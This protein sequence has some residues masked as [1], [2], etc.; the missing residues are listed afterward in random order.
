MLDRFFRDLR[1]EPDLA[2]NIVHWHREPARNAVLSEFPDWTP[3]AVREAFARTGVEQLWSHQRAAA[4]LAHAGKHVAVVTPTASGKTLCYN[5]PVLT[6]LMGDEPTAATVASGIRKPEAGPSEMGPP[7]DGARA[8]YLFPTKAL[9]RDQ[10]ASF[11]ELTK[12]LPKRIRAGVYDGDTPPAT[13][14]TLRAAADVVVTNPYMLHAGILPHHLRWAS[15]FRDLR[16]VV[17]DEMHTLTGVLGS[18]VANVLRRL[19]R[20]CRHHGS[21]PTFLF[22]SATLANPGELA[23]NLIGDARAGNARTETDHTENNRTEE[24]QSGRERV[25]VLSRCGA[26]SPERHLLL[27]NPPIVDEASGARFSALEEARRI[28]SYALRA[29]LQTLVFARS[30]NSVE[31]LTK[32]L[33]DTAHEL[34]LDPAIV[35]GYRGGYLPNLRREVECGLR[36]GSVRV[37]VATNALELGIDVGGLDVVILTGY[38][39]RVASARQQA[40]RSGRRGQPGTAV[41]VARSDPLD[42]YVIQHPE[43]LLEGHAERAAIDPLNKLI[44]ANHVRCAAFE[45]PFREGELLWG[46]TQTTGVLEGLAAPGGPLHRSGGRYHWCD[47]SFPADTVSLNGFDID[48]VAIYDLEA[49]VVLAEVDRASAPFF[50]HEGAI[51]GHQG[52]TYYVERFD[53]DGRRAYVRKVDCDYY[54]DAEAEVEVRTTAQDDVEQFAV[55]SGAVTSVAGTSGAGTSGAG[56]SGA[57][58][59]N[60]VF[61]AACGTVLVSTTV[62][63]Y[64]K[65]RYYTGENVGAGE[66]RLPAEVMG[67]GA[68]WIDIGSDL[69]SEMR[70]LEGGRSQALRGV[71]SLL[72]AVAPAFVRSDRGDLRVHSEV[73]AATTGLPRIIAFDRV[74]NG[75]GLAEAVYT[76]LRPI[77]AAMRDIVESCACDK[78]CPSCVGPVGNVGPYGKKVAKRLL[79]VLVQASKET[80]ERRPVDMAPP[81]TESPVVFDATDSR[82]VGAG[83]DSGRALPASFGVP[84]TRAR[85]VAETPSRFSGDALARDALSGD[86]LSGSA[87]PGDD[88]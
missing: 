73:R 6:A 23:S 72:R 79:A 87:S 88:V 80:P 77:L 64:K 31:V 63:L 76:C 61:S 75:V 70:I 62:P 43:T 13:R 11:A 71:A 44:F 21:D 56:T 74:P 4:D 45:L 25:E 20:I 28:A 78:G 42:Q 33:K 48:N 12:G 46:E 2:P 53:Y 84:E 81:I 54:T 65:I 66:I 8:L 10:L 32:Y 9:S 82:G 51:Y 36:D 22:C 67:T 1:T 16:Y 3:P 83:L 27:F 35:R 40:G 15:L 37:V 41:L 49:R 14:R 85:A 26:P 29:G 86:A 17:V 69:A 5:L 57:G 38:P 55:T 34:G 60:D 30:R 19:R 50:V 7:G 47:A 52:E 39:G 18:N 59:T 68:C 58:A 24:N